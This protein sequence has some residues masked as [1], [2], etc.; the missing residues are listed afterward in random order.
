MG[1]LL[2]PYDTPDGS[3]RPGARDPRSH[4]RSPAARGH[5]ARSLDPSAPD[6]DPSSRPPPRR[7]ARR[8]TPPDSAAHDDTVTTDGGA[9]SVAARARLRAPAS[10]IEVFFSCSESNRGAPR[11]ARDAPRH[12]QAQGRHPRLARRRDRRWR[13]ARHGARRAP[14]DREGHPPAHQRG[15][16]RVG[17]LLRRRDAEG[18]RAP[19][20]G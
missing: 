19:R 6:P 5:V 11:Q 15:L 7:S 16:P 17:L 2:L 9:R 20:S 4:V 13:G 1:F 12:P 10:P 14:R 8:P 3:S 18:D